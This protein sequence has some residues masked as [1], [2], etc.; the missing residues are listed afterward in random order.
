MRRLFFAAGI[1]LWLAIAFECQ[2][3]PGP[4]FFVTL[5]REGEATPRQFFRFEYFTP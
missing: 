1:L 3:R 5:S 2:G 4:T